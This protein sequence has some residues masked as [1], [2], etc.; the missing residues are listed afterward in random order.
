M[1]KIFKYA[2]DIAMAH[3]VV[4]LVAIAIGWI[5]TGID[6]FMCKL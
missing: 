3:I 5:W 6:Y 2:D 1:K 4:G